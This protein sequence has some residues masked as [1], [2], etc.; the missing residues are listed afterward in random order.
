M[1]VISS[2]EKHIY[3]QNGAHF[4]VSSPMNNDSIQNLQK[5][6]DNLRN[7]YTTTDNAMHSFFWAYNKLSNSIVVDDSSIVT[8]YDIFHQL[9]ILVVWL[10]HNGYTLLGSFYYRIGNIIE[11][12]SITGNGRLIRHNTLLD[13]LD[14]NDLNK[15]YQNLPL[16]EKILLDLK[17]KIKQFNICDTKDIYMDLSDTI[18]VQENVLPQENISTSTQ[19]NSLLV[20]YPVTSHATSH[21]T[22]CATNLDINHIEIIREEENI[23]IKTIM[24]RLTVAENKLK[25]LTKS[26]RLLLKICAIIGIFTASSF[27]L[28]LTFGQDTIINDESI[29]YYLF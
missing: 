20:K 11:Y 29:N 23:M 9:S 5:Y 8:D 4:K 13:I 24:E 16:D 6:I 14:I 19:E 21:A 12:I 17:D 18:Q 22:S 10:F 1:A 26:N 27:I 2:G 7:T 25:H 28:Y 3:Y 15:K